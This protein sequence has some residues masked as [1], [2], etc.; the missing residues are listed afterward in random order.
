[1]LF[2]QGILLSSITC[3]DP[4][5]PLQRNDV[6]ERQTPGAEDRELQ[7]RRTVIEHLAEQRI[8]MGDN[9]SELVG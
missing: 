5:S 3:T 8:Q 1:M 2:K 6:S 7:R 9:G 4:E